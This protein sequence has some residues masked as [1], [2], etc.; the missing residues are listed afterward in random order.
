MNFHVSKNT[1]FKKTKKRGWVEFKTL[2]AVVK[3]KGIEEL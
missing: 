3:K 2:D 1:I